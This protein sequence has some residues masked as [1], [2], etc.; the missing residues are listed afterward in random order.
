MNRVAFLGGL[1]FACAGIAHA[2]SNYT[3]AQRS[4]FTVG[5]QAQTNLF[6]KLPYQPVT[7]TTYVPCTIDGSPRPQP[8]YLYSSWYSLQPTAE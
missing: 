1:A 5:A 2:Q 7:D 4:A 8:S 6:V 3:F